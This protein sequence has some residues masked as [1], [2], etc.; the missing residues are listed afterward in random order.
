MVFIT[1]CRVHVRSRNFV[2]SLSKHIWIVRLLYPAVECWT[3][4]WQKDRWRSVS[5]VGRGFR[6]QRACFGVFFVTSFCWL[7]QMHQSSIYLSNR[8]CY[9][10]SLFGISSWSKYQFFTIFYA[11]YDIRGSVQMGRQ[12]TRWWEK[13]NII[14][15]ELEIF[16]WNFFMP[17]CVRNAAATWD[18]PCVWPIPIV[19]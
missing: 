15:I 8:C 10:R 16:R 18:A 3:R 5:R 6:V 12:C 17:F 9:A 11:K 1:D 7:S 14:S 4:V 2:Q 13:M 19:Q